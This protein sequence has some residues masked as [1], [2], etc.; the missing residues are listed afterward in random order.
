MS[1]Q[2]HVC[3]HEGG[4][5]FRWTCADGERFHA[6]VADLKRAFPWEAG[7]RFDEDTRS[8]RLPAYRRGAFTAWA[9]AH[10]APE[11]QVWERDRTGGAHSGRRAGQGRRT[12]IEQAPLSPLDAAYATLHLRS[13]APLWAA[14]AMYRAAQKRAHP[15]AG[16]S[17]D[18]AVAINQA[19]MM[20]RAAWEGR[21][22]VA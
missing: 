15:D 1:A 10:F 18:E 9:N 2:L 6:L 5:L 3:A 20:I 13:H 11:D 21:A 17:N 19:I 22:S 8:W 4:L 16:G 14:E 7:L 12:S